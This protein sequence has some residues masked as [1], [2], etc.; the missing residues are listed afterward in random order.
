MIDG[1]QGYKRNRSRYLYLIAAIVVLIGA[2][3]IL[4]IMQKKIGSY[5]PYR[6]IMT[7]PD[8]ETI[9]QNGNLFRLSN[10]QKPFTYIQFVDPRENNDIELL[11]NIYRNWIDY[12]LS[13]IV[14]TNDIQRLLERCVVDMNKITVLSD[15]KKLR[16]TFLTPGKNGRFFLYDAGRKLITKG[17][18]DTGYDNSIKIVLK[19]VILNQ[20]FDVNGFIG[21]GKNLSGFDWL[22]QLA[23]IAGEN[24]RRYY[25]FGLFSMIKYSTCSDLPIIKFFEFVHA[26]FP[27]N[28]VSVVIMLRDT[29]NSEDVQV[30]HSQ[31]KS[32]IPIIIADAKLGK[33]WSALIS[34]YREAD[35]NNIAVLVEG[36]RNIVFVSDP[37]CN[38]FPKLIEIFN[39]KVSENAK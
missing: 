3:W 31:M 34:E 4:N 24:P 9:D 33:K 20:R 25:L 19:R 7:L 26:R 13:I 10:L 37:A 11:E 38:C 29:Y 35:L 12:P 6:L 27:E 22:K 16:E 1:S 15:Y 30:I 14:I 28:Q 39:K 8:Y 36:S 21:Q 5:D 23:D 17:S 18:N 2:S 32:N